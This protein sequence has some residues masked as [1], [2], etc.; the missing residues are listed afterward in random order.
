M[1]QGFFLFVFAV[2]L[3]I[4]LLQSL[5]SAVRRQD[6]G[7]NRSRGTRV[8]AVVS[9]VARRVDPSP[10]DENPAPTPTAA[11]EWYIECTWIDPRSGAAY[12]FRSDE[13]DAATA[14]TYALGSP[15]SVLIAPGKPD[16][17]FVEV[18]EP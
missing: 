2:I 16:R 8:A 18:A 14:A 3:A 1:T 13:V 12:T 6:T 9:H 4:L 7:A 11:D 5:L 15:I 17:Y 10:P